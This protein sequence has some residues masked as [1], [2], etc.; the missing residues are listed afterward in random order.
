MPKR[1]TN[2]YPLI[3]DIDNIKFAHQQARKDKSYYDAVKKTDENLDERAQVISKMLL[4]HKYKV[5]LY[6]TSRYSDRGKDRILYKLPY[7]PD[8]IIQWVLMLQIDPYFKK[9]FLPFTCASLPQRG[10]HQ[11]SKILTKYLYKNKHRKMYCLKIDIK[12]FYP[13]INRTILK[14]LLRKLF[15][16]KD[17]L[18][19]LDNIIDSFDNNDVYKL[20]LTEKEKEVYCQPGRGVPVGSYLSQYLANFYLAYFDHWLV[21]QCHC[22]QVIRYMDD[23]VIFSDNKNFLHN[24]LCAIKIYLKEE[25]DLQLKDTYSIFPAAAGID[26]VGFRHF[27]TYKLL[28]K[29][30]YKNFKKNFIQVNK[31]EE[32]T[33]KDWCSVVSECGWLTWCN[34]YNFY[35]KYVFPLMGKIGSYYWF[36]KRGKNKWKEFLLFLKY[37]DKHSTNMKIYKYRKSHNKIHKKGE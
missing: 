12:K 24:L 19:E 5:G 9:V 32:I 20:N 28:R 16:D 35:K 31:K 17:L 29:S 22:E 14:Q 34:S 4:E 11:A 15:K 33:D 8:G 2:I 21:E 30:S 10:I 27:S 13:S 7:Y 36:N 1:A 25:L 6:K 37:E 23:I 18:F 26:F 3:C